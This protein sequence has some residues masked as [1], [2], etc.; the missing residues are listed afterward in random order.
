[1]RDRVLRDPKPTGI[2]LDVGHNG[3]GLMEP[4]PG[5]AGRIVFIEALQMTGGRLIATR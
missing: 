2:S 4:R 5:I 1:M 3:L